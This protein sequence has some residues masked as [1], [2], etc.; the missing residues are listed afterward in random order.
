MSGVSYPVTS[1][2][3]SERDKILEFHPNFDIRHNYDGRAV[4]SKHRAH[5]TLDKIP[6]SVSVLEVN[7]NP[8]LMTEG[9]GHLKISKD[10]TWNRTRNLPTGGVAPQ[11][12]IP[13]MP[14]I[15]V[16]SLV[17]VRFSFTVTSCGHLEHREEWS[18]TCR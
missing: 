4:S 17:F 3:H 15:C 13:P 2:E 14:H 11:L 9:I 10:N 12:N 18:L 5:F 6:L 1:H 7:C 16:R 8:G